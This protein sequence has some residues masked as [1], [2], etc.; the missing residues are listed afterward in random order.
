MGNLTIR[1]GQIL[2]RLTWRLYEHIYRRYDEMEHE[3][4][5][6]AVEDDLILDIDILLEDLDRQYRTL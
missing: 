3:G 5:N 6:Q 2:K 1:D 4:V